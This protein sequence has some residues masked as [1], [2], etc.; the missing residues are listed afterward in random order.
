M[1]IDISTDE[2]KKE[3]YDLFDSFS[4]KKEIYEYYDVID[5]SH[6][7]RYVNNIAKEIGFDFSIYKQRKIKIVHCK[8]CGKLLDDP[9][10]KFC[11]SSCA[12]SYNNSKRKLSQESKQKISK[13][14]STEKISNPDYRY[15]KSLKGYHL[16]EQLYKN[17]LKERKCEICGLTEWN[18]KEI[19]LQLHHINGKHYDN[20]LENLQI[21]C[22]N[23]HSQTDNY[24]NKNRKKH[25]TS[26]QLFC[27]KCGKE[28]FYT[29]KSGMCAE[30]YNKYLR[31]TKR[32][33]KEILIKDMKTYQ[34]RSSLGRHY[35]VCSKTISKWLNQYQIDFE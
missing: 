14:L 25:K 32:P 1:Y 5:N 9:V 18:G 19:T 15:S 23:C 34:S 6:N 17:G 31:E 11:N 35:K 7:I 21:L 3:V 12:A 10:K 26:E 2:K 8:Y 27:K 28:L 16:R 30:C 22:P 13:T 33:S 24:C 29:N 4:Y 20:R